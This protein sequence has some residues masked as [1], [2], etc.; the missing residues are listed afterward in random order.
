MYI[1]NILFLVLSITGTKCYSKKSFN[2]NDS[3]KCIEK[4]FD[5]K[6]IILDNAS[7][8]IQNKISFLTN[9]KLKDSLVIPT[10]FNNKQD[11]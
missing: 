4:S 3:D 7:D 5:V 9:I 11:Y 8:M 6:N 10:D 1:Y 2:K